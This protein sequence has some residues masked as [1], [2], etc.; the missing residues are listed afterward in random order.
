LSGLVDRAHVF[1][2][3][4]GMLGAGADASLVG[5]LLDSDVPVPN[6]TLTQRGQVVGRTLNSRFS[7]AMQCAIAFAILTG[8]W[9]AGGLLAGATPCRPVAL[10][11]LP[12]PAPIG[13]T[14]NA[15][16]AVQDT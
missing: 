1:N 2:G 6:L 14:E 15:P 8:P 12:I 9:P 3:R 11:F 10:P 5:V 7:P 4:A 13:A 16:T